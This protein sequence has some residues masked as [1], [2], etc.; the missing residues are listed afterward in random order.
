MT[1]F[2]KWL[3]CFAIFFA[4]FSGTNALSSDP[5][6]MPAKIG[7]SVTVDGT[8][9][10]QATAA[11]YTFA[12]TKQD[13]TVYCTP[14]GQC[15]QTSG[16]NAYDN[17]LISIPIYVENTTPGGANPGD[18]AVI[19]VYQNGTELTVTSPGSGEFIVGAAGTTT[20]VDI[21]ASNQA[22]TP[23]SITVPPSSSTGSYTVSWGSSSTSGVTYILEEATNS[24][25]TSGLR[26][27]Y[28]GDSLSAPITG[29]SSG[30]TYYYRVKA[31]KSGYADSSQRTGGNGCA[32]NTNVPVIL[33]YSEDFDTDPGLTLTDTPSSGERF[34]WNST[35]EIYEIRVHDEHDVYKYA[36]TPEFNRVKDTSFVVEVDLRPVTISFGQGMRIIFYDTNSGYDVKSLSFQQGGTTNANFRIAGVGMDTQQTPDTTLGTWYR[37]RFAYNHT[38][39]TADILII[40]R[41]SKNIFY[42]KNDVHF[43]PDGFNRCAMGDHTYNGE[44]SW[45]EMHYDNISVGTD[46]ASAQLLYVRSD[47][48][49]AGKTPCYTS[50]QRAINAAVTGATMRIA[51]GTY[52]E[53]ITLNT[54]KSLILQGGWNSDFSSQ[55]PNTTFIRAPRASQGSL[56]LQMV[57]IRP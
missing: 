27:A 56:N 19:H 31:T 6:K 30:V 13:G 24:S 35:N 10:T 25:F 41:D 28:S 45:A 5:P 9:L 4:L 11:G 49:C 32:V 1:I 57:T 55:T 18:T 7:G 12:V 15:A 23:T 29:R 46:G 20:Q 16:L 43:A 2:K 26:Q 51:Q 17:Y 37:V 21:S 53:S 50:I 22:G 36:L 38:K 52:S 14:Q 34:T 8:K 42:Q 40:E 47:G 3:W 44:G 54:G 33:I 48:I 39:G